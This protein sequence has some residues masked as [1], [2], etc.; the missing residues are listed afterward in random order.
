[1][2]AKYPETEETLEALINLHAE[3]KYVSFDNIFNEV[4]RIRLSKI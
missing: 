4:K 1:M 2:D 3:T